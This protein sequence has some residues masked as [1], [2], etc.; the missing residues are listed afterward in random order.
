MK[1]YFSNERH[2]AETGEAVLDLSNKEDS[3]TL[4][5]YFLRDHRGRK[6]LADLLTNDA[7]SFGSQLEVIRNL[8]ESGKLEEAKAAIDGVLTSDPV[9][10]LELAL[11]TAR[12]FYFKGD[13]Q[14]C[15]TV[16]EFLVNHK[17]T[18]PTTRMTAYQLLGLSFYHL[19]QPLDGLQFLEKSLKMWE[20]FPYA[21][22]G[23][24]SNAY[25]VKIYSELNRRD[26]AENQLE[27]FAHR[28][29]QIKSVES[30]LPMYLTFL[31]AKFHFLKT[32]NFAAA[33]TIYAESCVISEWLEDW[34]TKEKCDNDL[35]EFPEL[36]KEPAHSIL[37][38]QSWI[39][40]L[41][42]RLLLHLQP[43]KVFS[44]ADSPIIESLILLLSKGETS[45]DQLFSQVW[46][47]PYIKERHSAHLRSTLSS[48]RKKLPPSCLTV[49]GG[50]VSLR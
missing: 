32:H 30:W 39:Y 25:V 43:K 31:R 12:Y 29:Q 36:N 48:L 24:V 5:S 1:K 4:F 38:G 28:L 2:L 15:R 46:K 35:V 14:S 6:D 8:F 13:W 22:G 33:A 21:H 7:N 47:F 18:L 37:R 45:E 44:L 9:E 40:L 50:I 42:S 19:G 27:Q 26:M 34:Q 20:L 10:K 16:T 17:K 41:E 23:A 11:E 3:T 49:R